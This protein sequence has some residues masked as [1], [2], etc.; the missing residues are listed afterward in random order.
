M[1][2]DLAEVVLTCRAL[3]A[4]YGVDVFP[5]GKEAYTT[6]DSRGRYVIGVPFIPDMGDGE[7]AMLRGYIDH[8]CGHVKYTDMAGSDARLDGV[9][10]KYFETSTV[11]VRPEEHPF[12]EQQLK[13]WVHTVW[14]IFEDIRVEHLMGLDFPGCK[15]NFKKLAIEV[16]NEN[17]A[18]DS[19]AGIYNSLS[20]AL[21][22]DAMTLYLLYAVRAAVVP[23]LRPAKDALSKELYGGLRYRGKNIDMEVYGRDINALARLYAYDPKDSF[24]ATY[25]F[26]LLVRDLLSAYGDDNDSVSIRTYANS[27]GAL[28][29]KTAGKSKSEQDT[30]VKVACGNN[31]AG[32]GRSTDV[33]SMTK[34]EMS[35]R[36]LRPAGSDKRAPRELSSALQELQSF[37]AYD[38]VGEFQAGSREDGFS[39]SSRKTRQIMELQPDMVSGVDSIAASAGGRLASVLQSETYQRCRSGWSGRLDGRRLHRAGV[40]DGRVF[41]RRAERKALHTEVIILYDASGSMQYTTVGTSWD[42][43]GYAAVAS[44]GLLKALRN[45]PHVRSAVWAFQ[46]IACVPMA[47]FDMPVP[48]KYLRPYGGTPLG[49]SVFRLLG[50][51]TS[52]PDWRRILFIMSDGVPDS[53][54]LFRSA[55]TA[56]ER[57]G[58]ETYGIGI[59]TD[60]MNFFFPEERRLELY[61][62]RKLVPGMFTMM[63]RAMLKGVHHA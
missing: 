28:D 2:H 30:T 15:Y 29:T 56:A 11:R 4:Q 59:R 1:K 33:S 16:F 3:S 44:Y 19:L 18:L 21:L 7:W 61:D 32:V 5:T 54:T 14:N 34:H 46:N 58:V 57:S 20:T 49:A 13:P 26:M 38:S 10:R 47:K 42:N 55:L 31:A 50:E 25:Q 43:A 37:Q 8:E 62:L 48:G 39:S 24:D 36:A 41:S 27:L 23:E 6:V 51:Y 9:L 52:Q 63:Q 17:N 40:G 45:I 12:M 35:S 60:A 22:R 53:S